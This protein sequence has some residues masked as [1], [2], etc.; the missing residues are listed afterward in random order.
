MGHLTPHPIDLDAL[1]RRVA[2]SGR[3]A[4]ATFLG[5]VR[6]H[7]AGRQV[8]ALEYQAYGPMAEAACGTI[9]EEA[10]HRWPCRVALEHRTGRLEIGEIAVGIAVGAGHRAEAFEACR[11]VIDELK[12]RV[13]IWKREFYVDGTEAWVDPTAPG[14]TVPSGRTP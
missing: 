3:G 12:R 4:V 5:L 10:E 11:W 9:V 13:P 6:D 8:V 14:G 2:A 7:H 1:V